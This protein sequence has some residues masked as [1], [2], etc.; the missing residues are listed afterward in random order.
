MNENKPGELE[1]NKP[2]VVT[3]T[4]SSNLDAFI[5]LGNYPLKAKHLAKSSL[6]KI[7]FF[8][9]TGEKCIIIYVDRNN[10]AQA[11]SSMQNAEDRMNEK[12]VNV[13]IAPEGTRRKRNSNRNDHSENLQEFK[14]GAFHLAKN[15]GVPIAPVVLYG[16]NRI[17]RGILKQGTIVAQALKPIPKEKVEQL[18]VDEMIDYCRGYMKDEMRKKNGVITNELLETKKYT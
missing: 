18:S 15:V 8:G 12:K 2:C 10:R 7:P 1:T 13:A 14:K 9:W 3:Y 5:L 4:H 11:M 6:R 16:C 17:D